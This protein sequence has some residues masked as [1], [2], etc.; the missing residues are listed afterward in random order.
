M[1]GRV[2][3]FLKGSWDL[4]TLDVSSKLPSYQPDTITSQRG[5]VLCKLSLKPQQIHQLESQS[6]TLHLA[7][8]HQSIT[9]RNGDFVSTITDHVSKASICL[10]QDEGPLTPNV[11]AEVS[12]ISS[13]T[14]K[15]GVLSSSLDCSWGWAESTE[16]YSNHLASQRGLQPLTALQQRG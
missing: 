14:E 6:L 7:G 15:A 3:F 2:P 11:P 10:Q 5:L 8:S 16:G 13:P 1:L 9:G 12:A 4:L